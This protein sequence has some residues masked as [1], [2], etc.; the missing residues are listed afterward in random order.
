[1]TLTQIIEKLLEN[2]L[3]I[4]DE[5]KHLNFAI[6]QIQSLIPSEEEIAEILYSFQEDCGFAM[7]KD[8]AVKKAK[9]IHDDLQ[10]RLK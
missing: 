1:M 5:N 3:A 10:E 4:D 7:H 2:T 8:L 6:S 9:A